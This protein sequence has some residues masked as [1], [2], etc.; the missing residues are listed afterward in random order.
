MSEIYLLIHLKHL[1]PDFSETETLH[2]L[3][4]IE[5]SLIHQIM[6]VQ[7]MFLYYTT[8]S[9]GMPIS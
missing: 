5:V 4:E 2:M 7:L 6:V 1:V 9:L 3:C 8:L